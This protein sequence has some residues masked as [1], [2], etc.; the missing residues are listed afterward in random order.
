[1]HVVAG[2]ALVGNR[3]DQAL[4][5]GSR[6]IEHPLERSPV[7]LVGS[8]VGGQDPAELQCGPWSLVELSR[9]I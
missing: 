2:P 9:V 4:I 1:M 5:D 8:Y 6:G 3:D 7:E